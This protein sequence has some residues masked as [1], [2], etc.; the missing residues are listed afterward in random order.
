MVQ[1]GLC[2][3]A[4]HEGK[5]LMKKFILITAGLGL[6]AIAVLAYLCNSLFDTL[7]YERNARQTEPA[8]R[9]RLER[10]KQQQAETEPEPEPNHEPESN[11]QEETI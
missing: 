2:E 3:I 6:A 5:K 10:L 1:K 7:T 8:R 9:A 4:L 11:G